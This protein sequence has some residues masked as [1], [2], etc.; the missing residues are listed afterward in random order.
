MVVVVADAPIDQ[1][2]RFG[3]TRLFRRQAGDDQYQSSAIP[4]SRGGETVTG[5]LRMTGLQTVR[6]DVLIE[7]R[8]AVVLRNAVPFEDLVRIVVIVLRKVRSE[9]HTS[10]LQSLM[11]ISYA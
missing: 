7:Q 2:L 1:S 4:F 8:V 6:T 5:G 10:E 3:G 9:E 11:R